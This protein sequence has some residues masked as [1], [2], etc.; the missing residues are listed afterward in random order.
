MDVLSKRSAGGQITTGGHL[1]SEI[2]QSYYTVLSE[3][4]QRLWKLVV[5]VSDDEWDRFV[6]TESYLRYYVINLS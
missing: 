5:I 3:L 2:T 1:Q 4:D 6:K